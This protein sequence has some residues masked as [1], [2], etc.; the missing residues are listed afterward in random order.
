MSGPRPK[1]PVSTEELFRSHAPFVARFLYRFGVSADDLDDAVQEVF[2]VVHRNGGYTPG[3]ATPTSY[4]ASIAVRAAASHRRRGRTN[5][6]RRADVAPD[7][8]PSAAGGPVQILETRESLMELQAALERLEPNLRATLVL[9]ELEG[10]TCKSI[11]ASLRIPVGTVYW[12][13]HRARKTFR[14]AVEEGHRADVGEARLGGERRMEEMATRGILFWKSKSPAD[15][16]LEAARQQSPV[17]YDAATALLRHQAL[18]R[19]AAK[20]PSWAG[21]AVAAATTTTAGVALTAPVVVS[22]IVAVSAVG[23]GVAWRHAEKKPAAGLAPSVLVLAS[24]AEEG[25]PEVAAHSL[26]QAPSSAPV[27]TARMLPPTA[28]RSDREPSVAVPAPPPAKNDP[29]ENLG[30]VHEAPSPSLARLGGGPA[31]EAAPPHDARVVEAQPA[32]QAGSQPPQAQG[33]RD[34]DEIA[35]V[36]EVATAEQLLATAPARA[37]TLVRSGEA[38][39]AHGYLREERRYIGVIALFKLGRL[40][41]ARA[42]AARFLSDYPDGPFSERVRGAIL[43]ANTRG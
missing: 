8:V 25:A 38:R 23:G 27:E 33:P 11:A 9:V 15:A 1:E 5:R 6:E 14:L 37:L 36:R 42:E 7:Q 3:P 31:T 41:E 18:V 19:S 22:A 39:F 4:L 24:A 32:A 21:S 17:H 16:L 30:A 12:R 34:L 26:Q 10:E 13:L 35:E 20:L 43:R 29:S 2:L 28:A 40:D